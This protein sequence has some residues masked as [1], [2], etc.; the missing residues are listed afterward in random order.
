MT[1]QN[2]PGQGK[3]FV[4]SK[5]PWLIAAAA[6]V[7]YLATFNPWVSLNN[8]VPVA[9]STGKLVS[10]NLGDY[11]SMG[12]Y[13]PLT[14]CLTYPLSWLPAAQVPLAFNVFSLVCALL[15]LTLLA[16]SVALLP[17]NR[18]EAQRLRERNRSG[19]LTI[20]SAWLPPVLAT[21]AC[22][23]QITFWEHATGGSNAMVDL[24]VLAYVIR[25]ILE[26][27][28]S[29]RIS[30]LLRAAVVFGAGM[31]NGYVLFCL[32]PFFLIALVW[33]R[34]LGFFEPGFLIKMV[35]CGAAGLLFYLLLPM[36]YVASGEAT[37]SFWQA[38]KFNLSAEKNTFLYFA[39]KLPKNR[40][41]LLMLT[42]FLPVLVMGIR[43][44]SRFGDPS[45]MG[46]RLTALVFHLAHVCLLVACV[47][48]AF[49]PKFSPKVILSS[50]VPGL[51]LALGYLSALSVG[52]FAGYF[53]LVLRPIPDHLGRINRLELR[54]HQGSVA[55]VVALLILV[56]AGLIF[57]NAPQIAL[58]N[59]PA[60][61]EFAAL[62]ADDLPDRAVVLG[63]PDNP[64]YSDIPRRLILTQLWMERKGRGK[65][66]YFLDTG[67]LNLPVYQVKQQKL[68]QGDWPVLADPKS[69]KAIDDRTLMNLLLHLS[70]KHPVYYLHPSFGYY[71]EIF[72]PQPDGLKLTLTPYST[73]SLSGPPLTESQI[74]A[75]QEFWRTNRPALERLIPF[76]SQP[77]TDRESP[78]RRALMERLHVAF[79]ANRTA[80]TLGVFYSQ[81][82]NFWGVQ[83]Q[84]AGKLPEAEQHFQTAIDLF[85]NNIA[86]AANL[87]FNRDL[88]AGRQ[89]PFQIPASLDEELGSY[90]DLQQ[91][92]R[93]T[94]PFDD[95]HHTF[96]QAVV[97]ALGNL[98]RQSAQQFERVHEIEPD[99]LNVLVW[100][101]RLYIVNQLPDK[102]L[103]L[104][105]NL[106]PKPAE[107]ERA[108]IDRLDILQIEA[109]A[110]FAADRPEAGDRCLMEALQKNPND[111]ELIGKVVQLCTTF[112]RFTNAI[113]ALDRQLVLKPDD[114]GALVGK[115][116]LDMQLGRFPEA[117][118]ALTRAL[119]LQTNNYN[120]QLYRAVAYL[121]CERL[122]DAE[123][124]YQTLQKIFPTSVEV[125]AGLGDIALRR[126]DTNTAV[127][128]YEICAANSAPGSDQSRFY[129][130]RV[131]NLKPP[132]AP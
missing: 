4:A 83:L 1:I 80:A 14:Y 61:K 45:R 25:C 123:H 76:I 99:N 40:L 64:P 57:K 49:D 84:R 28:L 95:P 19:Q 92:L 31:A 42:S 59:G 47:W 17:H 18:T 132:P 91:V 131:K 112:K 27:R 88:Q 93:D 128:F 38:L 16:R 50:M 104:I 43:W 110:H 23:L 48:V 82:L 51:N 122:D 73:N 68:H 20:R 87:E 127:R 32:S 13:G 77:P 125:N 33:T 52:Y 12:P 96:G 78:L 98:V 24:L 46:T 69:P 126:Q 8:L 34:R 44:P 7:V 60:M 111:L 26:Y 118:P 3:N 54:L 129:S 39:G 108:N 5:L 115:G 72:A 29:E 100:L 81:T 71:F 11:S 65:D 30:W 62:L 22:G 103:D 86:A 79:E 113:I 107:F 56:P 119:Q 106:H 35:L 21:M 37:A 70:E 2:E 124:D 130:E 117:I 63:D 67:S 109:T 36:I 75:N 89:Q 66:C 116:F 55:F 94:G 120:A 41:L 90:R 15:T 85:P 101:A 102:A 97:F 105:A 74:A 58:T 6:L 53:L 121:N 10:P 9:R 114:T